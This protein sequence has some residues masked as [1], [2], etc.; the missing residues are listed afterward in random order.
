MAILN[1]RQL[2]DEI[3]TKKCKK[4]K[5]ITPRIRELVDDMYETMYDAGGVGLAAPQ[6]GILKRIVVID[7]TP[8]PEEGEELSEDEIM[9]FTMINPEILESSGEQRGYEGCLSY[10]GM[11]GVVTRPNHVKVRFTD[12]EG[13]EYEL[14]GEGLLAR[15]ICHELDHLDG[16]MYTDRAEPGS[17]ISNE[18]LAKLAE[19]RAKEAQEE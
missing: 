19:E 5:M 15:C 8:E 13:D 1:V 12:I 9:R 10:V 18:E 6:V 17:V 2:G 4:V 16:H 7:V 11:S 3:L 14:E